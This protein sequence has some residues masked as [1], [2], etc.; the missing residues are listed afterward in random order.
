MKLIGSF[1][2][3]SFAIQAQII[4]L[5]GVVWLGLV[6]GIPYGWK[7]L[8]GESSWLARLPVLSPAPTSTSAK[9]KI[10]G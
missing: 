2:A 10:P 5:H 9:P 6:G 8:K 1:I 4:D 3:H 7:H